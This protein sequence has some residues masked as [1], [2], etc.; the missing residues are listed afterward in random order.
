MLGSW[1]GVLFEVLFIPT[2]AVRAVLE[3]RQLKAELKGYD[4]YLQ[5]VRCRFIPGI[6]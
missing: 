4:E 2:F 1:V 6:C 3:E 5:K